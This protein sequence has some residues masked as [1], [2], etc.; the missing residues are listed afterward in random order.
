[1][2]HYRKAVLVAFLIVLVTM[3][4]GCSAPA[5]QTVEPTIAAE[6]EP[7]EPVEV[8]ESNEG[9]QEEPAEEPTEEPAAEET[10]PS[11]E[12]VE[13]PAET[14]EAATAEPAA[15][16]VPQGGTFTMAIQSDVPFQPLYA[17][18]TN[19]VWP[20]RVVFSQ[21]V[22]IDENAVPSP[23]LAERWEHS[24]DGTEWTFYLN[25]DAV[26]HD[27]EPVTAEDV[28]FTF[29]NIL[30]PEVGSFQIAD[31]GGLEEV[32]VEDTH[33]V[34]FVLSE[35]NAWWPQ[36]MAFN[37]YIIPKHILEGQPLDQATEFNTTNPIGSG[38][39]RVQEVVLGSHV[40][41]E[42]F[43]DHF[44]GRPNIDTLIFKVLPDIN[45]QVAQLLTGEL[46]YVTVPAQNLSAITNQ[47]GIEVMILPQATTLMLNY[48]HDSPYLQDVRVREALIYGLDRQLIIDQVS[49]GVGILGEG[50]LSPAITGYFHEDLPI[51]E[52]DPEHAI[53]LL[54]EA[55]WEDTDGD[56]ILD[57]DIDG[58]GTRVPLELRLISDQG[59]PGREQVTVIAQQYW[60]ALGIRVN[61]EILERTVWASLLRARPGAKEGLG[62]CDCDVYVSNRSYQEN[63]DRMRSFWYT[64][65]STNVGNYSN[66]EIDALLDLGK[67]TFD[68]EER[69]EIYREFQEMFV[70]DAPWVLVYYDPEKVGKNEN[71][72]MVDIFM[73]DA[74][75]WADEWY[76]TEP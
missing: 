52:Y 56:G 32:V 34:R 31:L 50:P 62:S 6:D 42:A 24:E 65:S 74:L 53:Q 73:R 68:E 67:E 11:E 13:E 16:E 70:A 63:P 39:Y 17:R 57:N 59:D 30:D 5:P 3:L 75:S 7:A 66:P 47:P 1:M 19:G 14:E 76:F 25:Q 64:D 29:D 38:P 27:G 18:G 36:Q 55:G 26:W 41:V 33:T 72:N 46:D 54:N 49:G 28:K 58:S 2:N 22:R 4:I 20:L 48:N 9:E 37:M 61:A 44:R 45:T 51:R 8:E 21:L 40:V 69:V 35:P 15:E 71:L 10:E 60:E 43:E 12:P 23:D